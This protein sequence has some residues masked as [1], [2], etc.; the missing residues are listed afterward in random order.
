MNNKLSLQL[1][2]KDVEKIKKLKEI[3]NDFYKTVGK[4]SRHFYTD[5][6]VDR[7][8]R[9]KRALWEKKLKKKSYEKTRIMEIKNIRKSVERLYKKEIINEAANKAKEILNSE[10]VYT[11]DRLLFK[12]VSYD[13]KETKDT[14]DELI[15][16]VKRSA[17][18]ENN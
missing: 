15:R 11:S 10:G 2:S 8:I 9:R 5:A 1:F 13:E 6:E 3:K 17:K 16:L 7:I 4:E 14:I 18:K 12:L